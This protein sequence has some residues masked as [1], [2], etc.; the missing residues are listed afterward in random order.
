MQ[1]VRPLFSPTVTRLLMGL[2]VVGFLLVHGLADDNV[3]YQNAAELTNALIKAN[4]PFDQFV[5]PDK[6]HGIYGGNTRL[7][8]YEMMT[9]W[10]QENL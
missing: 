8:L 10:V 5:Y 7:H 2:L 4:K 6:N 9:K 3:H 1:P